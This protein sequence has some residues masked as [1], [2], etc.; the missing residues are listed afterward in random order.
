MPDTSSRLS[1]TVGLREVKSLGQTEAP[2]IA[3]LW[4]QPTINQDLYGEAVETLQSP[5]GT[6]WLGVSRG[7]RMLH[8]LGKSVRC[9]R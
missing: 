9:A 4:P 7:Y 6:P 1:F 5:E 3:K 2:S 8:M